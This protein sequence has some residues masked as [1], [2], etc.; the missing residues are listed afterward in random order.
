MLSVF[1]QNGTGAGRRYV[2]ALKDWFCPKC[3]REI[4]K[5]WSK[6]P[7]CGTERPA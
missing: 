3:Q 7:K 4:E 6:C 5:Y 1:V 2:R